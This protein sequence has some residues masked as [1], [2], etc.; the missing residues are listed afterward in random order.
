MS[1]VPISFLAE[2]TGMA[3]VVLFQDGGTVATILGS[4]LALQTILWAVILFFV[5]HLIA[6]AIPARARGAAVALAGGCL[7]A[8]A[9]FLP[10]YA[11]PFVRDGSP[12]NLLA[13]F[14]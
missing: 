6:R 9:L 14:Q 3:T 7:L 8:I 13:L 12:V 1:W 11:T 5:A 4:A 10:A 2:I